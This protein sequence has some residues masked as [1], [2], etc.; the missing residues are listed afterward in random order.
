MKGD[1]AGGARRLCRRPCRAG[2]IRCGRNLMSAW[3]SVRLGLVD[4]YLGRKEDALSEARRA[5]AASA[6]WQKLP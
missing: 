2:R 3:R 1:T 5:V 4:A 6:C